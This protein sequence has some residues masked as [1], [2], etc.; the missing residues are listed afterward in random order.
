LT[1]PAAAKSAGRTRR[2]KPPPRHPRARRRPP[3]AVPFRSR[4]E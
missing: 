2:A 3:A 4:V 1:S